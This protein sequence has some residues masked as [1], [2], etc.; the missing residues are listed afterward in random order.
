MK[1]TTKFSHG[2]EVFV[3][4]TKPVS[5]KIQCDTCQCTG[6]VELK[7]HSF[8]CPNCKGACL[9]SEYV[10]T[11]WFISM[12]SIVAKI[13]IEHLW[14]KYVLSRD[15]NQIQ[16]KYMLEATG[17]PSGTVYQ[18]TDLFKT[19]ELAVKECNKRNAESRFIFED[20]TLTARATK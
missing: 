17:A 19:R 6:K 16:I 14:S 10:G 20:D 18:E 15:T 3:I 9:R 5:R 2:D 8:D 1:Y 4:S 12:C 7:G 11:F 13:S